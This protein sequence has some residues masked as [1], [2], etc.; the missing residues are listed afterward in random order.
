MGV[1]RRSCRPP[2][3]RAEIGSSG[4]LPGLVSRSAID[5]RGAGVHCTVSL[6]MKPI[7]TAVHQNVCEAPASTMPRRISD[8][9]GAGI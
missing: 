5:G 6:V 2:M 1:W 9:E 7:T 3:R 4:G 8:R